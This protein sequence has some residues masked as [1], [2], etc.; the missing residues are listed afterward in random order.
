VSAQQAPIHEDHQPLSYA[1]QTC[2]GGVHA[3][4]VER[5]LVTHANL[6]RG[7]CLLAAGLL[8]PWS[9]RAGNSACPGRQ[10]VCVPTLRGAMLSPM[11]GR[12]GSMLP[13]LALTAGCSLSI[14]ASQVHPS[15]AA[16]PATSEDSQEARNQT[17]L[18]T[19]A[20]DLKCE[21]V[22]IVLMFDRRYANSAYLRY[23]IE[24]CGQRGLRKHVDHIVNGEIDGHE[25]GYHR[26]GAKAY[27]IQYAK[28]KPVDRWV[29]WYANG[30]KESEET[31]V[32][33]KLDGATIRW[34]EDG[35]LLEDQLPTG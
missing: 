7:F 27:E 15:V 20:A 6:V 35:T 14:P 11:H 28:G 13:L 34:R 21:R 12:L 22:G 1:V 19:A 29:H 9:A 33:D 16:A 10:L 8:D 25:I 23:V 30:K 26:D 4:L 24:G 2:P 17:A 5:R 32:E 18:R 31:Y 3:L